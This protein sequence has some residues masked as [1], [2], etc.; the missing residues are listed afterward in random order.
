MHTYHSWA[1]QMSIDELARLY[2]SKDISPVEVTS[3]LLNQIEL[4][5]PV[6]NSFITICGKQ[7]LRQALESEKRFLRGEPLDWLDG[8]PYGAKD[9][10][11]TKN[12]PTTMG[13][14]YYK[15]FLPEYDADAIERLTRKGAVLLGKTNTQ[16]FAM[17]ATGDRSYFGP[18]RNPYDLTRISGG[19]SSGSAAAVCAG[20]CHFALATDTGGSARLPA[21]LCG[22]VGIKPTYGRISTR[23]IFPASTTF[24]TAGIITKS[25]RDNALVLNA[26]A[27]WDPLHPL[28]LNQPNEDFTR[29]FGHTLKGM[30][31]HIPYER[32]LGQ[33]EPEIE[34]IFLNAVRILENHGA[35]IKEMK[36]PDYCQYRERRTKILFAEAYAV[37]QE[38]YSR[39]P[40]VY[41]ADVQQDLENGKKISAPEYI[42]YM[43]A[44]REFSMIFRNLFQGIEIMAYPST[45]VTATPLNYRGNLTVNG[46]VTNLYEALSRFNWFTSMSGYPAITI[47]MGKSNHLPVGIQFAAHKLDEAKLYQIARHL[48]GLL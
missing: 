36:F 11:Y 22:V 39:F 8:I 3:L 46:K 43:N 2:R 13:C 5:Q 30:T 47:P 19:S 26:L 40:D 38:L 48:E 12:I 37:H 45:S 18:T 28:S 14:S 24:D 23:G 27:G 29:L 44:N 31:I 20:L 10:F 6:L 7:A 34:A 16:Q 9:L 21:A 32:I 15:D 4:S 1:S 17:G 33:T 25:V 35:C 41:D 42:R